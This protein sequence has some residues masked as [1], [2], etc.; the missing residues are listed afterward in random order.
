MK[1]LKFVSLLSILLLLMACPHDH[2]KS[3]M[4]INNSDMD[5]YVYC[6]I[7]ADSESGDYLYLDTAITFIR[8]GSL[9][10][11]GRRYAYRYH[12]I[13][14]QVDTWC[15]FIF[16]AD[17]FNLCTWDEIKSGYKILQR[18]DLS[19]QDCKILKDSI[20]YP[21]DER[22]KYMKMYPPYER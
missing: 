1:L 9:Y 21:P 2:G 17:T 6:G 14:T 15:L 22:M 12:D 4:F 19:P 11:K 16:D 7:G 10:E 13:G 18:Y 20:I 5:V 3:F 8:A